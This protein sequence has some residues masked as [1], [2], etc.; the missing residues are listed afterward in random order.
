MTQDQVAMRAGISKPYLSNIETEKAK[1]PP[2][3]TILTALEQCL[4]FQA[5]ELTHLAHLA[6]TPL[7]VRQQH[8]ELAAELQKLR[9]VLTGLLHGSPRNKAGQVDLDRLAQKLKKAGEPGALA[10]GVVVPVINKVATGYPMRF[11]GADYPSAISG[12]YVR[13]PDVH[14]AKAFAVR[15]VDDR[16]EPRYHPEDIVVI[17]PAHQAQPGQDCFVHFADGSTTFRRYY[18]EAEGAV[19]L[20][21]L[22]SEYPAEIH[23]GSKI[24]ALWPAVYRIER[25]V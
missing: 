21:P 2:S 15:V 5:N 14:D 7:D 8:E 24:V 22:N 12:E 3:D 13:C 16:M 17:S 1:N 20:Q 10:A 23:D 9:G 18:P 11:T 6:R 4:G 25:L 19:R